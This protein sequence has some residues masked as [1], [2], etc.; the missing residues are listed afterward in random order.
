MW[1]VSEAL[2]GPERLFIRILQLLSIQI[3][4]PNKTVFFLSQL[5]AQT[6]NQN[7]FTFFNSYS[8]I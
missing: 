8:S 1:N 7:K 5:T 4:N 2:V 3:P 6:E